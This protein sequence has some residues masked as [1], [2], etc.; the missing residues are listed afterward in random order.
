VTVLFVFLEFFVLIT[1]APQSGE[2]WCK[3]RRRKDS[4]WLP[5]LVLAATTRV[6]AAAAAAAA[7]ATTTATTTAAAISTMARTPLAIAVGAC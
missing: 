7:A 1:P 4:A 5:P 2:K 3:A 6:A